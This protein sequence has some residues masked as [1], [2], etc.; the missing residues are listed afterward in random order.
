[1]TIDTQKTF[2]NMQIAHLF[3]LEA[4]HNAGR[5]SGTWQI[6]EAFVRQNEAVASRVSFG[7]SGVILMTTIPG[8]PTS[9]AFYLYDARTKTF[10]MLDFEGQDNFTPSQFDVVVEAYGLNSLVSFPIA[11]REQR[12]ERNHRS[13]RSRHHHHGRRP[14][15]R[16]T[17]LVEAA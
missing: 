12:V 17:I 2:G 16:P 7:T 4:I 14:S 8:D 15:A 1:M 11:E 13:D 10:F 3:G 9:G 5:N 6:I